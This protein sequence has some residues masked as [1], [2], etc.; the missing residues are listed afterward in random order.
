SCRRPGGAFVG[1]PRAGA[2]ETTMKD[3]IVAVRDTLDANSV[4]WRLASRIVARVFAERTFGFEGLRVGRNESFED[5]LRGR[6]NQ[7]VACLAF[8]QI[9]RRAPERAG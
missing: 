1:S 7:Q 4:L 6:R 8:D 9:H 2:G 3:R 5:N